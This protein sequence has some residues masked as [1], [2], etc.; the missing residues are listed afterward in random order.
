M[1][2]PTKINDVI[3][4]MKAK[5]ELQRESGTYTSGI[6][7]QVISKSDHPQG[8]FVKLIDGN[9]GR[10]KEIL[11]SR[12]LSRGSN[13]S[14]KFIEENYIVEPE[15]T[16]IE[17][18]QHFI[19]FHNEATTPEKK[20]VVE[21]SVFKAIAAFANGEGGKLIIGIHD[22]GTIFGLEKDYEELKKIKERK[23]KSIYK[24]DR[25]GM[26]LKIKNDCSYYFQNENARYALDLIKTINFFIIN[27]KEICEILISPSYEYPLIL[28]DK[29]ADLQTK[30]GPVFYVRKG[31]S[32]EQ[33]TINDFFQYW[34]RRLKKSAN[35]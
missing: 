8:I 7:E 1:N 30:K 28:Y 13:S 22:N 26:E 25:D 2:D 29:D 11:D 34:V 35:F 14:Q 9:K 31:N 19:Y 5:I 20:W 10:V 18:K 3:S 24:P 23:P 21:H 17:Y 32:S 6:I 4:G 16:K 33:Y 27:N 12:I 15:S